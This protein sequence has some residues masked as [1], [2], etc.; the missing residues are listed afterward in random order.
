MI[1]SSFMN[2]VLAHMHQVKNTKFIIQTRMLLRIKLDDINNYPTIKG[3]KTRLSQANKD[4][5]PPGIRN[6]LGTNG[7]NPIQGS[8]KKAM[9][10]LNGFLVQDETGFSGGGTPCHQTLSLFFATAQHP[11]LL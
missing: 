4:I 3:M 8:L 7:K 11:S 6:V 2:A 5:W 10:M 9:C 1:L